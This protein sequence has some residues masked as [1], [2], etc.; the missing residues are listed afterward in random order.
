MSFVMVVVMPEERLRRVK[1]VLTAVSGV[2]MIRPRPAE[3][4]V[5]KRAL[6]LFVVVKRRSPVKVL[7]ALKST[8]A[9]GMIKLPLPVIGQLNVISRA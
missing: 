4:L 9:L 3:L 2:T 7:V 6:I 1:A 8:Q 5:L